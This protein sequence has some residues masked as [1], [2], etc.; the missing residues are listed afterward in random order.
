[1]IRHFFSNSIQFVMSFVFHTN[2]LIKLPSVIFQF[3]IKL[4]EFFEESYMVLVNI[5]DVVQ[6]VLHLLKT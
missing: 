5:L 4:L 1:M 3:F 6:I 2:I